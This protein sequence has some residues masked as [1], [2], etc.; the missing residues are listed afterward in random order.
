ME[1]FY[2]ISDESSLV[3]GTMTRKQQLGLL[4]LLAALIIYAA[5]RWM[6]LP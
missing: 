3:N 2:A 4:V 6:N 5:Y 1:H